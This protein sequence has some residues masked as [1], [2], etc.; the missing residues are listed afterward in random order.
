MLD[1]G[2]IFSKLNPLAII[3][4]AVILGIFIS[5][6]VVSLVLRKRYFTMLRD[7]QDDK[8]KEA[9]IF[10][11]KVFNNI[12]DDYK[13]A[14]KANVKE[15]N[16]QAI[17]EKNFNKDLS[18]MYLG[19][20]F[21]KRAVSLM[22]VLG[23]LGTFYGLTLSIG[24]LVK[25]LAASGGIDVLDSMDSV[26]E[27]LISSVKGM[28]VAFVTSLFGIA[29]SIF[30]TIINIFFGVEEVREAVMIEMEEYLDNV[31]SQHI[32]K[33]SE[34]PE[35]LIKNELIAGLEDFNNKLQQNMR[36]ITEVLSFRFESA[37]SGIE[38]FSESLIKSVDRFD[39]SLNVFAENTRDFSEFNHH[40]KTNIQRMNVSFN[41]FTEELKENTKEIA[42]GLQIDNLSK[43]VE[44]LAEKI[45]K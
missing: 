37:T 1:L 45:D 5:A 25:T 21:V 12:I 27:G 8:N 23:L 9:S 22:I 17:I 28:S 14:V 10:E 31:L 42:I 32:T 40:L 11:H 38:Q 3:I 15:I 4:I 6:F 7:L 29:S 26:I 18:S 36:E 43:S 30:L 41:D 2:N 19:E 24:E 16:T 34:T 35:T 39:K 13:L 20:K 33:E 44:K